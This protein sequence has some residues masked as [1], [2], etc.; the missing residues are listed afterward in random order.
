MVRKIC[1]DSDV[2]I[3]LLKNNEKTKTQ[4]NSLDAT[5]YITSINVFEIWSG[6]WTKKEKIISDLINSLEI[7]DFDK[8]SSL[9]AGDIRINL[10]K[11]REP[12]EIRDIFIASTCISNN[13]ELLT[14]NKKHFK[15]L[16]KFGIK[17][18]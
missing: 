17:L 18:V 4:I 15:R 6:R 3:E 12:I 9:K 13:I 16:E 14:Y 2:L 11:R 7:I 10:N 1:L 8:E 5:F